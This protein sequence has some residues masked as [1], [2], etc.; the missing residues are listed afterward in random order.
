MSESTWEV[1]YTDKRTLRQFNEDGSENSFGLIEQDNLF[2]FRLYHNGKVISLFLPSGTFGF[3]GLLHDTNISQLNAKYRL[4]YFVRRTK[5]MGTG[6]AQG[7]ATNK[8]FFIA[9]PL[10]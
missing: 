6:V 8:Y 2:E 4:V 5:L 1:V 3:N 7:I 9:T 10:R